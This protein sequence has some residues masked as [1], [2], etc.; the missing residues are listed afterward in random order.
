MIIGIDALVHARQAESR[1]TPGSASN[2]ENTED[3]EKPLLSSS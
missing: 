2:T 1:A 3:T